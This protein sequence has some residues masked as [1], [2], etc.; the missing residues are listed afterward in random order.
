[1]AI[2]KAVDSTQLD[3]DLT[4]VANAIRT[5][6]GTSA[7]L[8]F[9]AGF[10]SAVQNIPTGTTPSGTKQISITQNGTTTE[11]VAAYANAEITVNVQGGGGVGGLANM[12]DVN[13]QDYSVA[14]M[15]M[16]MKKGQ[17]V[18]GTVTFAEA[19]PNTETLLLSTGLSALHGFMLVGTDQKTIENTGSAQAS[20]FLICMFYEDGTFFNVG[21]QS[22]TASDTALPG[23][24]A[25]SQNTLIANSPI[26]GTI[27]VSGGDL[28]YT[29]RYNK[30]ASY[31]IIV[32]NKPYE[33]L[34]W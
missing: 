9:P 4:S 15:L 31:Q 24:T 12:V 27:R 3:S 21:V 32:P 20:K 30:N 2:D 26:N 18:G 29:G 7:Q 25:S 19:F 34:A 6:G 28:Y 5:K 14:Y 11:D 33:W 13:S 22:S 1:M 8:A 16:C 23:R 17:T 10:V